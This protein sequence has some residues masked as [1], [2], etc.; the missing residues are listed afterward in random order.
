MGVSKHI[1]RSL[2][3]LV[4]LVA[5]I[6]GSSCA[7]P[8]DICRF[9]PANCPNGGPGAFCDNDKDCDGFCC[10]DDKNCA[11]GMCT[12]ECKS[13]NECPPDMACEHDMCFYACKHD[14]DCADGQKCEHGHTVCEW[15]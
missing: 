4:A 13:D 8:G 2:A 1:A 15:P 9:D 12:Y 7:D 11:G 5:G 3:L 14:R 6:A 10:T